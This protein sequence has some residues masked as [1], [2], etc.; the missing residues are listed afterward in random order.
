M[1]AEL[2]VSVVHDDTPK[3]TVST[4]PSLPNE[5]IVKFCNANGDFINIVMTTSQVKEFAERL[6]SAVTD[7][8]STLPP[9]AGDKTKGDA[10][11]ALRRAEE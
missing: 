2:L 9:Y 10:F 8:L 5:R 6:L 3:V 11:E 4:L 7:S 1:Y